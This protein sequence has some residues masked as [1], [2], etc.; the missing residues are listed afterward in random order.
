MRAGTDAWV[1][2]PRPQL[3]PP[4]RLFCIPFAGGNASV[5]GDWPNLLPEAVEVCAIQMPGRQQ[6]M[7]E[8]PLLELGPL[9]D[10]LEEAL[11]P[12]TRVPFAVFGN[13]TGSLIAFE[14]ARRLERSGRELAQL[15]VSCCRAPQLP[16]RDAPVHAL[17]DEKIVAELD[18]LG[19]TPREIID[20]PELLPLI[21][22]TLRA[23]F[24][25]AETYVYAEGSPLDAPIAAFGGLQDPIV[26]QGEIEE[27]RA[28][29]R[30]GFSLELVPGDHYMLM[31]ARDSL[32]TA[33]APHL[34]MLTAAGARA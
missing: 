15:F 25:L 11:E 19:G 7:S 6:R 26:R 2:R 24:Q 21:L 20:H 4:L 23:D 22:P 30:G 18:R 16:D 32:L 12:H 17:P 31:S 8:P 28:Q 10:R 27:W 9:V 14:L 5:F 1:V 13:C 33:M 29:T 3:A 34:E